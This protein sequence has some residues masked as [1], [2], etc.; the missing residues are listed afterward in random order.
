MIDLRYNRTNNLVN[1]A[2]MFSASG[3][4]T[5]IYK[6]DADMSILSSKKCSKCGEVK[7]LSSF[8]KRSSSKDGLRAECKACVLAYQHKEESRNRHAAYM[9]DYRSRDDVKER[10]RERDKDYYPEYYSK[11]A[12]TIKSR[13]RQWV[14]DNHD[15]KLEADK[16]YRANN[17][18]K[19]KEV[20]KDWVKRS[21]HILKAC[22]L[23]RDARVKNAEGWFS[24]EQWK[25]LV[26]YYCPDGRCLACGTIAKQTV[27]HVIPLISGGTNYIHNIQPLCGTC[28]R[29]KW[30]R[31]TDYRPDGGAYAR[32]LYDG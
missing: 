8:H 9:K 1:V 21:R 22:L 17:K 10:R 30:M 6:G 13:S 5:N 19:I 26:E 20:Y 23:K 25:A 28:N 4:V 24:G 29:S 27:D 31:D 7:S 18:E 16:T 32:S 12:E 14:A 2:A 15:R 3:Y 11:N